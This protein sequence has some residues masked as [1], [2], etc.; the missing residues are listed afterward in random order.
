MNQSED[1]RRIGLSGSD[2]ELFG[3]VSAVV[4]A[5]NNLSHGVQCSGVFP[6]SLGLRTENL[7]ANLY[8]DYIHGSVALILIVGRGWQN[9]DWDIPEGISRVELQ[10]MEFF[11]SRA[12]E[13]R[14]TVIPCLWQGSHEGENSRR[15]KTPKLFEAFRQRLRNEQLCVDFATVPQLIKQV[16]NSVMA[17]SEASEFDFDVALS[18]AGQDRKVAHQIALALQDRGIKVF[19]DDFFK[20]ELWGKDLAKYLGE[21]YEH[22]ARYCLMLT[23]RHYGFNFWTKHERQH[24]QS[25]QLREPEEYLLQVRLDDTEVP[26]IPGT[27]AYVRYSD[28][29]TVADLVKEKLLV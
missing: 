3:V 9:P 6:T 4:D 14:I 13:D 17:V 23:S 25:R 22:R 7:L 26:G 20:H 27:I 24:A 11:Y 21:V 18:F 28:F 15:Y 19:Y 8:S 2:S 10:Y 1:L 5:I 29:E 16:V 12:L